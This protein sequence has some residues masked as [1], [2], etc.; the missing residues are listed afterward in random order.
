MMGVATGLPLRADRTRPVHHWDSTLVPVAPLLLVGG[1]VAAL[2]IWVALTSG[3]YSDFVMW[4]DAGRALRE[5]RDLYFSE[6]SSPGFRNMNPPQQVVLMAPLAWLSI[7]DALVLWWLVTAAAMYGCVRLWGRV[8]PR[9]WAIALFALLLASA[10]GY[11]NIRAANQS[12]VM[13]WVVTLGWVLWRQ[14]RVRVAAAILGAAASIKL[15]LLILLPYF[16]WRRRWSAAGWF[17]AGAAAASALGL[18]VAGPHAFVSWFLAL[19]QQT[20]QGQVLSMSVLGGVTRFL[21]DATVLKP[22]IVR[23]EAILPTWVAAA[24]LLTLAV[25]HRLR[26]REDADRDFAAVLTLMLLV[27]PAGW[28]YYLPLAAG[29]LAAMRA[30]ST[31]RSSW[32]WMAGT[33]AL[34]FPYPLAGAGQ[35]SVWATATIASVYMWGGLLLLAATLGD[36]L[37]AVPAHSHPPSDATDESDLA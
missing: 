32:L 18:V 31:G 29:P 17:L 4:Y 23:P 13:A 28:V 10:A 34:L 1:L 33:L 22:L 15:F 35:P 37:R 7:R 36:E 19:S 24:G 21:D 12:W 9:G 8:L 30:K 14:E 3:K 20:W 25:A 6:V 2:V 27:T 16:I 11:L 26:D 5:G